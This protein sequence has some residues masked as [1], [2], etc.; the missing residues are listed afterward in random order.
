MSGNRQLGLHWGIKG[1]F[2]DYIAAISD[3]QALA[4]DG[5]T[6]TAGNVLVFE[7]A[8]PPPPEP[9][10][11]D[12]MLAFRGG[13]RFSGHSGLLFVRIID[14]WISVH[15]RDAVLTVRDPNKPDSRPR[16]PLARF[17]L[18]PRPAS[19]DI[20]IWV[21]KIVELAEEGTALFN[22]VYPAGEAMEPL[23]VFVRG[24][25]LR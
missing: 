8:P 16:L 23:A 9:E 7:P 1:S 19:G 21:S 12:L 25:T 24:S 6:P 22:D 20:R 14:P 4:T 10:D 15:G 13:V 3:G 11:A 2:M 5:A 18:E 17:T